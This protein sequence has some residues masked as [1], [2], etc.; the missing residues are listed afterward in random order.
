MNPGPPLVSDLAMPRGEDI[1]Q[2]LYLMTKDSRHMLNILASDLST[3][4][5]NYA[6]ITPQ[7]MPALGSYCIVLDHLIHKNIGSM[8]RALGRVIKTEAGTIYIKFAS[9][10]IV[11][12]AVNDIVVCTKNKYD[13]IIVDPLDLPLWGGMDEPLPPTASQHNIFLLQINLDFQE[14]DIRP[15]NHDMETNYFAGPLPEATNKS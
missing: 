4:I 12:R 9:G 10:R 7:H 3:R 13:E 14:S 2:S 11:S 5:I 1:R 15:G 8:N 6:N